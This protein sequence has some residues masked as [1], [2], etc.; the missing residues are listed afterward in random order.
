MMHDWYVITLRCRRCR[1]YRVLA[2]G[3]GLRFRKR[4]KL[5]FMSFVLR[6]WMNAAIVIE[7]VE[8]GTGP[9]WTMDVEQAV[10]ATNDCRNHVCVGRV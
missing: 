6:V 10:E 1:W 3:P 4:V 5:A 2:H 7:P 9:M 8:R